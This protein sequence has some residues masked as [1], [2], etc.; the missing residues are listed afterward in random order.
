MLGGSRQGLTTQ[1]RE[2]TSGKGR[3]SSLHSAAQVPLVTHRLGWC[4]GPVVQPEAP[5]ESMGSKAEQVDQLPHW[6]AVG[7]CL[8]FVTRSHSQGTCRARRN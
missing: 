7:V 4:R 8:L 5:V 3:E 2:E 1:Q 6:A